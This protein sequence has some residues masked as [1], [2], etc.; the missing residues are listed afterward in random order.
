MKILIEIDCEN[1]AFWPDP[2]EEIYR[3]L[4][5]AK[6]KVR[7]QADRPECLCDAP[8]SADKLLDYNGNTVGTVRVI[9]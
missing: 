3:L 9:V 2:F 6:T 8:E 5:Q 4:E 7:I 1:A